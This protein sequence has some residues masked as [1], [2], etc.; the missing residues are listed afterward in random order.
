MCNCKRCENRRR[1]WFAAR[2]RV[3]T[4]LS[5]GPAAAPASASASAGAD[6]KGAAGAA[7]APFAAL[8]FAVLAE[9]AVACGE[10]AEKYGRHNWRSGRVLASTYYAAALRHLVAWIEG[11][12]IDPDSGLSH[13]VKVM[14][15]LAVLRD[16]DLCGVLDDDRPPA[17]PP[18][19]MDRVNTAWS[20]VRARQSG[21]VS[22]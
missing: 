2:D 13:V 5:A 21:G 7:K 9:L 4:A 6:P 20:G 8:P 19:L 16:A 17:S 22:G 15:S 12:D 14:S 11:E 3:H 18:G 10:G 1:E